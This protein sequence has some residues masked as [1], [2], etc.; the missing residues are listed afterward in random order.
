MTETVSLTSDDV[1]K[2]LQDP[3]ADNRADAAQKVSAQFSTGTLTDGERTI[4]EDIFRSMVRDVEVRVRQAL[5]ESLRQNPEVPRDVAVSLAKDVA[6]VATPILESSTVLTDEDLIEI[7]KTKDAS[8]QM[9]VARR[10][11]VSET[12]SDVLVET[13]DEDVV[14]TLVGNEGAE[15]TE[16]TMNKVLDEFGESE[17]VNVPL[18]HR[19]QL[20]IQVAERLVNLVSESIKEHLVTHHE[21]SPNMA[22]D[23]VLASRE[24]ATV[25]LLEPGASMQDVTTLVD[26]LHAH[27]RLT[28]TI[29]IR[30][31][32]MGDVPFFEAA[33]AKRAGIPAANAY[34]LV[35]DRGELGLQRLFEKA[36]LPEGGLKIARAALAV[37]EEMNL[38]GGDDRETLR[39]LMIERVLTQFEDGFDADHLDYFISKLGATEHS[40]AA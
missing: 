16:T 36:D 37:A 40:A 39:Q 38:T 11:V 10:S 20:P 13:H 15:L 22:M 3:S 12:V 8:H 19:E 7:V 17:K 9:A 33:L 31:L 26:Q 24:K 27:D 6:E 25:S 2:L 29:I 21:M 32:C 30:A 34:K 18:A 14:A 5:S 1:A 35:H 4:A 23:L 28:P